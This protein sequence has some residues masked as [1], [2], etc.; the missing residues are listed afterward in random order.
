LLTGLEIPIEEAEKYRLQHEKAQARRQRYE[1]KSGRKRHDANETRAS[2]HERDIHYSDYRFVAWDGEAPKDTGYSLFGSSDGHELCHPRLGTVECLDLLLQAAS[3]DKYVINVWFGGRYDWDEI[4]RQEVPFTYLNRLKHSGVV[5]WKGYRLA[6]IPGKIYRISKDGTSTTLYEINSWFHKRY[7]EALRDYGV[8]TPEE[9]DFMDSEKN[10]RSEFLWEEIDEIRRY[11]RT[12]LKL[13]PVLMDKVRDICLKAGFTPRGWYGP[14]ALARQMI[15]RNK[16]REYM[17]ECPAEVNKASCYAFAGGRFE[18]FRGGIV[19]RNTTRDQNSAYVHAALDLPSLAHGTWRHGRKFE[20]GKFALYRIRYHDKEVFDPLRPYPL[21]RRLPNGTVCWPRRVEGWYWSPEA[22]LVAE[23]SAAT[24]LESWVFDEEDP[25][26]RPFAFVGEVYRQRLVFQ[27]L[28]EGNPS[29][30]AHMA[31][32]WALAAI[33]GQ[34]ARRVG[35]DKKLMKPPDTHQLEWAGYITSKCRAAQYREA[36]QYPDTL[37][38]IDTDSVTVMGDMK[39]HADEG[40][41]LGQWKTEVNDS[42]VF[43][44]SGIYFTEKDGKWGKGKAR[45]VEKR[46]KTPDLTPDMLKLAIR[47]NHAVHLTAR[48][49]YVTVKMAL[50]GRP[51]TAGLWREASEENKLVFGGGGKRYHNTLMCWK[52]CAGDVHGFIPA[53]Y[54]ESPFDIMSRPH[55]LPW[56]SKSPN[57]FRSG[58][59]TDTIWTDDETEDD[60]EEWLAKLA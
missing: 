37:M 13:M 10:R 59:F 58:T 35:W 15:T 22:E 53:F 51:E 48:R 5:H 25:A 19:K 3:E 36:I 9:L 49:R 26:L 32:K 47:G 43:F 45:G 56:Q 20:P 39:P 41:L 16:V 6:E 11:Y 42:G 29:R 1:D 52:Y 46:R 2:G 33:Y 38:S 57:V 17:A 31:L 40:S 4:L 34:L 55:I 60:E 54:A 23:D 8:G 18:S 21:F 27:N 7:V 12:E 30:E 24:F 50:N 44:Q 14:S 28:P